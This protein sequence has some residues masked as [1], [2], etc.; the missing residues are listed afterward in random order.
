MTQPRRNLVSL[1]DTP[2]YHC[3]ARC[4]RRAF[5]CGDDH[6]TGQS[7]EHRR[8]WVADRLSEL[9]DIFA[10]DICAYAIMHNHYHVILR[11]DASRALAWDIKT[12]I[13]RWHCLFRGN[14][15]SQRFLKGEC[16]SP[17][18]LYALNDCVAVWRERLMNISW[19]MKELNE[20]IAREANREDR[21]KGRFWE[22]R[23]KSQAL[24]DTTALLACMAYVDLNPVR[25]GIANSI[26]SS[27]FTSIQERLLAVAKTKHSSRFTKNVSS[28]IKRT[29]LLPFVESEHQSRSPNTLPFNLKD[30]FDL[31]DYTGRRVRE[32][33]RGAISQHLPRLLDQIG[34]SPQQWQLLAIDIQQQSLAALGSLE[35]LEIYHASIHKRWMP[36][37]AYLRRCY[38]STA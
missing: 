14:L 21:C 2:Y 18:E 12:V 37:Q 32:D 7:F 16:L 22:G 11:V 1:D 34:L 26:E 38:P 17:A 30:Y 33:K 28:N 31:V 35:Q 19:F 13:G 23:F 15:L 10:I 4:V 36:Q 20:F 25:A 8:R 24:L 6:L 9:A 29:K 27:D 5:L 3:V